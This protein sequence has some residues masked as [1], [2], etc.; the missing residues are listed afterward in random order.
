MRQDDKGKETQTEGR[1]VGE[2]GQRET[3]R[4]TRREAARAGREAAAGRAGS[5]GGGR[6]G[7][8]AGAVAT[9]YPYPLPTTSMSPL[10]PLTSLYHM[11][12]S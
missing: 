11:H 12:R 10:R 2:G 7:L 1:A 9:A 3:I 4:P 8:T 5:G 6:L